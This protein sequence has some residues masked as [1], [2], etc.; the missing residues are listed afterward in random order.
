MFENLKAVTFDV[1]ET[2]FF[3]F[4]ETVPHHE[5]KLTGE[6]ITAW[7]P[8]TGPN[9]FRIGLTAPVALAQKMAANFLGLEDKGTPSENLEDVLREM[10][11]MVAGNFLSHEQVAAAFRL[12]AP[13]SQRLDFAVKPWQPRPNSLLLMVDDNGLEIFLERTK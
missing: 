5:V 9:S 2:M 7:V 12:E 1:F 4:P 6:A 10:A 13:H 8:I 3:L 11:T